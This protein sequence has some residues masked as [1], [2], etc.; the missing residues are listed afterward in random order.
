[1]LK[2][3]FNLEIA[4]NYHFWRKQCTLSKQ[5]GPDGFKVIEIFFILASV[6]FFAITL[7]VP[8]AIKI[9][10]FWFYALFLFIISCVLKFSIKQRRHRLSKHCWYV[11][12]S[13]IQFYKSLFFA[14]VKADK[15]VVKLVA[16]PCGWEA[17]G[18]RHMT[19]HINKLFYLYEIMNLVNYLF[20]KYHIDYVIVLIL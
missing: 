9:Q 19:R 10:I 11:L 18:A 12:L 14:P 8:F 7:R 15:K 2:A 13:F 16:A 5:W 17:G 4:S 3:F 1:M 6:C 20:T